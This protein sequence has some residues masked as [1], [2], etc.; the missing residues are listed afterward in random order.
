MGALEALG[1]IHARMT[2]MSNSLKFLIGSSN[3]HGDLQVL[4]TAAQ[5]L[6]EAVDV[7]IAEEQREVLAASGGAP[8]LKGK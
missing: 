6:L 8:K 5:Q 3:R 7:L 2:T 4:R 1:I